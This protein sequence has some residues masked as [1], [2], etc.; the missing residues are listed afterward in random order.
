MKII[1]FFAYALYSLLRIV[2]VFV[3]TIALF[4]FLSFIQEKLFLPEDYII[5]VVKS[6]ASWLPLLFELYFIILFFRRTELLSFVKKHKKLFYPCFIVLN[7][8]LI[9]AFLFNVTVITS[10]KIIDYTFFSP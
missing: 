6:P 4:A 3:L 2:L 8:I 10:N 7:L 1:R 5:C 9:Y